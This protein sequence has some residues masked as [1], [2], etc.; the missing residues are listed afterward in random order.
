MEWTTAIPASVLQ[1]RGL[2]ASAAERWGC[3]PMQPNSIGDRPTL[4]LGT[5]MPSMGI[6]VRARRYPCIPPSTAGDRPGA[7]S[8]TSTQRVF[9]VLESALGLNALFS[10]GRRTIRSLWC[11]LHHM[12]ILHCC[13]LMPDRL[14]RR[15]NH[16]TNERRFPMALPRTLKPTKTCAGISDLN[17]MPGSFCLPASVCR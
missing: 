8:L 5:N 4:C 10:N 11:S 6:L 7:P 15:S 13:L 1:R 17:T 16:G 14:K 12:H 9:G 2:N 3:S